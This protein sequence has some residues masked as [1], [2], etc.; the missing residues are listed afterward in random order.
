MPVPRD[1][2]RCEV[3]LPGLYGHG[4]TAAGWFSCSNLWNPRAGYLPREV[5]GDS[6]CDEYHCD[7][8]AIEQVRVKAKGHSYVPTLVNEFALWLKAK[9]VSEADA[10]RPTHQEICRRT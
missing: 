2:T 3:R 6:S 10:D 5:D 1:S 4:N 8:I 9:T 7:P